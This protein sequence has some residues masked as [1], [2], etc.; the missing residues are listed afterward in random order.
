MT[1]INKGN[2]T[3]VDY[4]NEFSYKANKSNLNI[5]FNRIA[6]IFFIFLMISFIYSIKVFYLGSL[7]S[8]F[9]QKKIIQIKTNFRADIIDNNGNFIAKTVNALIVGINPNLIIDEKKLL[10]N[11]QLIFPDKDF[12]KVKKRIKKKKY[13][14]LEKELSQYQIERLR[15]LGDKSIKFEEQITRVYPQQN[16]FSHILGQIDDENN[17]ISGIEKFFDYELKKRNEPLKL[18][19]D[20]D[21]QF[22]I[23][24]ELIK[25]QEIFN[26]IGSAAILMNV[27]NGNILSMVSLP[28][29]NLNKR[30]EIK[31]DNYIYSLRIQCFFQR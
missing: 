17:G 2:L 24:K 6:F 1:E 21:I 19:V 9:L 13:F 14:R 16:L 29:F 27:N 20:T 7:H 3:L 10:I 25:F 23:R 11:L 30:Q 4:E 15:L 31:D 22:L 18:T 26:N 5:S 28:D 8:K 12:K